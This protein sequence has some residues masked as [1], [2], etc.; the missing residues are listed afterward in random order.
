MS[1]PKQIQDSDIYFN[2]IGEFLEEYDKY[3][4]GEEKD[5]QSY[6][7][8]VNKYQ[9][10]V[11]SNME[12]TILNTIEEKLKARLT[13]ELPDA[14]PTEIEE[15]MPEN[16]KV[17]IMFIVNQYSTE[18]IE[19]D[20]SEKFK[21]SDVIEYVEKLIENSDDTLDQMLDNFVYAIKNGTKSS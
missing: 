1:N 3:L 4:K 21:V 16:L 14:T 12:K 17:F 9:S 6:N 2:S 19:F 8:L 7:K 11:D 5:L 15:I 18:D 13:K 10:S 20:A